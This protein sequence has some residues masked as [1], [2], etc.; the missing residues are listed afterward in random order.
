MTLP[1]RRASNYHSQV[2]A[3][4]GTNGKTSTVWFARQLL[5]AAGIRSVSFGTLGIVSETDRNPNP[6][7]FPGRIGV[8]LLLDQ[9]ESMDA[10]VIVWE[11]FSSALASGVLDD[12]GPTAAALTTLGRDH[13]DGHRTWARYVKAK[14]RLFR[15][16]LPPDG[17]AVLPSDR[18][19]GQRFQRITAERGQ[20]VCIFGRA[21]RAHVKLRSERS[22]P[23]GTCINVTIDEVQYVGR[24]PVVGTVMV[25]NVLA[26][27][28]L[29]HAAG[30]DAASLISGLD[31]L[32]PP[33]GRIEHVATIN[34]AR[35]YVDYAH[36]AA[37]LEAVL[38]TLRR[39]TRSRIHLVFGCGG[40]RDTDKRSEMGAIAQRLADLVI[41]TDDNPRHEE[42]SQIRAA[43]LAACPAANEVPD[44]SE[45]IGMALDRLRPGDTLVVA[46]K[47]HETA[48]R[49][50]DEDLP[51]SDKEVIKHFISDYDTSKPYLAA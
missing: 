9:M 42:P 7:C 15:D 41:V 51:F 46:G 47:G 13:R 45:A 36:T 40:E 20:R 12:L 17:V 11:A 3:V 30:V 48:Q 6:H 38:R 39:R 19:E 37:A 27:L 10:E 33:P 35:V 34:K 22:V 32:E 16:V 31:A 50:G 25:D 26:A 1:L 18:P 5:E 14:E 44:R 49:I 21:P 29:V 2:L 8:E 4:T 24:V 28:A 23:G 43:I